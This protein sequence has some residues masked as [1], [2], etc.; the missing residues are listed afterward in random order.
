MR[1]TTMRLGDETE[2]AIEAFG[3]GSQRP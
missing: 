2:D 1:A 3:I